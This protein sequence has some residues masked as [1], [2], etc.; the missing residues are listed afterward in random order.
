MLSLFNVVLL[1]GIM[2]ICSGCATGLT[3]ETTAM[4]VP[5]R[6]GQNVKSVKIV[7]AEN[8]PYVVSGDKSERFEGLTRE[9]Y[10]IPISR[11][12]ND[13]KTMSRYLA[14]R[15]KVGFDRS[16]FNAA[17]LDVPKG[18]NVS[19]LKSIGGGSNTDLTFFIDMRDW[20]YDMGG[21]RPSFKFDITI[22]IY[23][24]DKG[25]IAQEDFSGVERMPT[26]GWKH[27]KSRYAELYQ[28]IFDSIFLSERIANGLRGEGNIP[29]LEGPSA[30]ERIK[31]LQSMVEDGLITSEEMDREKRRILNE[32]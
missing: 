23:A 17:I 14:E 19:N 7:V 12:T 11:E 18:Q 4:R 24:K 13:G 22:L 10:G 16:G 26:G 29:P 30:E 2:S 3:P 6:A 32:I 31:R 25:V 27:F 5:H 21:F 20:R 15:L 28:T 1:A 9:V 8:R